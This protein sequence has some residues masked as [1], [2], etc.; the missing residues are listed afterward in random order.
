MFPLVQ[1]PKKFKEEIPIEVK[2][3]EKFPLVQLPKKF[4][5]FQ[6]VQD[7]QIDVSNSEF[8]LVQLPKKFKAW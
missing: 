8:P 1:L 5:D 2:I 4:K 3:G 6:D 7:L